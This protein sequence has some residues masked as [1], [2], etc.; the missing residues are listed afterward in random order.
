MRGPQRAGQP[1]ERIVLQVIGNVKLSLSGNRTSPLYDIRC[2][3][4]FGALHDIKFD[5]LSLAQRSEPFTFD[6]GIMD[7]DIFPIV[8]LDEAIALAVA[9][10]LDPAICHRDILLFDP[11]VSYARM[12]SDPTAAAKARPSNKTTKKTAGAKPMCPGGRLG[13][14]RIN[15]RGRTFLSSPVIYRH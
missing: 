4:S 6:R 14:A 3:Q 15:S 13:I 9:E 10:P 5:F 1:G 11:C 2:L 8:A 12:G 7:E